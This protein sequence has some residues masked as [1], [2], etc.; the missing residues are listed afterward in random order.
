[1]Q[2]QVPHIANAEQVEKYL[3]EATQAELRDNHAAACRDLHERC[4]VLA[5]RRGEIDADE[6]EAI[7]EANELQVWREYALP[8]LSAYLEHVFGYTPRVADERERVARELMD[9]PH[10]R[11]CLRAGWAWAKVR[12]VTRV[13]TRKTEAAWLDA[14]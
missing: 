10:T 12:E 14:T 11:A 3:D 1:M 2:E 7:N 5:R 8:H 13:A 4:L 9:L 6:A